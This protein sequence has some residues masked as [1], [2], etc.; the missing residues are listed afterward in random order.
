MRR[1]LRSLIAELQVIPHVLHDRSN[2]SDWA[3]EPVFRDAEPRGP[4]R[5]PRVLGR[6]SQ[7]SHRHSDGCGDGDG[8]PHHFHSPK[9]GCLLQLA[10]PLLNDGVRSSAALYPLKPAYT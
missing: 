3:S 1:V 8:H 9:E 4:H 10:M 2:L 7:P 6:P 5:P